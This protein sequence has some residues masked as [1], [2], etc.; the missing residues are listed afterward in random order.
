[1]DTA[2]LSPSRV[3]VPGTVRLPLSRGDYVIIKQR[4][5]AG[6]TMDLFERAASELDGTLNARKVGM[7]ITVTYLL[8][9]SLM[10]PEGAV[11][12]IRDASAAEKDAALRLLDFESVMEIQK[13][14]TAHDAA[15]RQEKKPP[16][17]E[18]A[19]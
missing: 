6:E 17:I 11:I 19:S 9:W 15:S 2:V 13:A 12:P 18:R 16:S 1:M 3:V 8:D 10:D 5:N 7:A 4:L 14:I